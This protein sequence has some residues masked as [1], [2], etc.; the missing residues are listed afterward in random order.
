MRG[1]RW[2]GDRAC[3]VYAAC[4][5]R[6]DYSMSAQG[7]GGVHFEHF[8]HVCDAG[9]VEAQRLVERPRLLPRVRRRAYNARGAPI[10]REWEAGMLMG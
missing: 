3:S 5:E 1:G 6:L 10:K 9:R 4:R 2:S 7:A 8:L